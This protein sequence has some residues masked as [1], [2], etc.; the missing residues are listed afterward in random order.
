[1]DDCQFLHCTWLEGQKYFNTLFCERNSQKRTGSGP[2]FP[3][4]MKDNWVK[5]G[6]K[7]P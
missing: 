1:M 5:T 6:R 2:L 4:G 3:K 7:V